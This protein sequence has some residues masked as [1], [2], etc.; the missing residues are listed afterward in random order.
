MLEVIEKLLL[1]QDRDR[2][3]HSLETE[4]SAID[5]QRRLARTKAEQTRNAA[6]AARQR[7]RQLESE[8]KELELEVVSKRQ[9]IEKYELQQYQTRKNDEYRA[10]THEIDTCKAAI[11]KIEDRE[12]DL[13]EQAEIAQNQVKTLSREAETLGRETERQLSELDQRETALRQRLAE[14]QAGRQ[15]LAASVEESAL[16]RYERLRQ[17]KGGRAVVG[18]EHSACGGC[19]VKL[20]PQVVLQCRSN[21]E[22]VLCPNCGRILYYTR[23][24]DLAVAE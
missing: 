16:P 20:P 24:M 7:V 12:L 3:I 9:Q 19:H 2:D 22:L 23:D 4:L 13:M 21:V 11:L 6:D 10:L 14:L 1:L 5:P 18:V 8:R 15:A 17:T